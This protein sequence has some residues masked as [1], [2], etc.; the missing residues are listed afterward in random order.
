MALIPEP[1]PRL[2]WI[3]NVVPEGYGDDLREL[4]KARGVEFELLHRVGDKE[5][6]D[7]MNRCLAL[8]YIPRLEPFG[9]ATLEANACGAAVIGVQEGGIRETVI[10]G[11]N[12]LLVLPEPGAIAAAIARLWRTPELARDLGAR[13]RELALEKWSLE[14][15]VDRLEGLLIQA[16]D[17]STQDRHPTR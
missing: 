7:L 14:T 5:L 9:F 16:R 10:D 4:A 2:V 11:Q 12:G 3:A 13:G 17:R 6:V 1:R 15:A 8:L